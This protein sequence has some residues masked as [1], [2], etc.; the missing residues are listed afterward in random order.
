MV[1]KKIVGRDVPLAYPNFSEEF[2]IHIDAVKTQLGGVT[3]RDGKPISFYSRKLNKEKISYTT[4]ERE[5][6][7]KVE[8]LK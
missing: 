8:T 1:T 3:I 6:L 2:I 7:S 4:T 5:L